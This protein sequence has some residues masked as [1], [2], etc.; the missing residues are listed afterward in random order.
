[1]DGWERKIAEA[2]LS[3][4]LV[5]PG[6]EGRDERN[7]MRLRSASIFPGFDDAGPD[8]KESY[9]EAA[10]ALERKG[11]LRLNWEKRGEGERLKTLSCGDMG[12]L[13]EAASGKDPRA[14]AGEIRVMLGHKISA[15][16]NSRP[17]GAGG[18]IGPA[19]FLR[20]LSEKICS[21][22]VARG[23][24][25]RA[26][27]DFIRLLEFL[28]AP[29]SDVNITTR[30]LSVFLYNDS[31]RLEYLLG[32]FSP[33]LSQ[34][35]KR[36][37]AAAS[38]AFPERSFPDTLISGKIVLDY[39]EHD[40]SCPEG[41]LSKRQSLI[42]A[43]GLV[44][45]LPLSSAVKI[46]AIR[47][48]AARESPAVLTVENK[49]TFYALGEAPGGGVSRYDCFLYTGGYP[50]QAAAAM[51]RILADSGFRFYHAG[52]LDP[53]GILILQNVGDIAGKTVTP[54]RMDAAAFDR[55]LFFARTLTTA[56]L[57]QLE[58]IREDTRA[59]PGLAGLIRRIEET[60]RG[61]EQEIIDYREL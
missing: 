18:G 49:E 54:L 13:F 35:R 24:D 32:L 51:I 38:L 52:D 31:K 16:E 33:L 59:I 5:S 46:R 2:F 43:G 10:E 48:I 17:E 1:M 23:L 19:P 11:L 47:T 4:H 20:F 27:E 6:Q 34:A 42:N 60:G 7:T 40:P 29:V 21:S 28:S 61:V 9:L 44:L 3:R 8:E 45:G 26:V 25:I 14:G 39:D 36:G 50:N 56:A 41:P 53:D 55:R 12:K 30:A 57:R 37:I 22:E 15:S 58:K